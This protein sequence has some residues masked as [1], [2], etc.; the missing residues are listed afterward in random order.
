MSETGQGSGGGEYVLGT[1]AVELARLGL[2]HRLWA[3][4]ADGLWRRANLTPGSRVLDI[5]CGPG[6][7]AMDMA[8]LTGPRGRVV[9]VDESEGFVREFG[10]QAR[11][12]GMAWAAS[13]AGDVQDLDGVVA[14]AGEGRAFDLAYC[15]WVLCFVKDPGRVVRAAA[16]LLKPGGRFCIQDY[17]CYATMSLAPKEPAF[18]AVINQIDRSWRDRGG[19]PDIVGRLPRLLADAGLRVTHLDVHH[20]IAR[21]GDFMWTWP[22]VFWESV[23]PRLVASGHITSSMRTEFESAWS[24]ASADPARFCF[25]PP[26]FDVVA[27]RV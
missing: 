14:R 24:R 6:F 22:T 3:D 4:A 8:A 18:T 15:R 13:Y 25:L 23:L 27:E 9:G 5:G 7:A 11:A 2:Q 1:D 17:F 12:R 16:S 26:V 20:R 21:P 19:D 10:A